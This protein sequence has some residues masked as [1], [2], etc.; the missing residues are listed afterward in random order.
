MTNQELEEYVGVIHQILCAQEKINEDLQRKID[1]LQQTVN[2][3]KQQIDFLTQNN[4]VLLKKNFSFINKEMLDYQMQLPVFGGENNEKKKH[5]LII[6]LTTFP[7]RIYDIKYTLFSLL[8]Q[9]LQADEILLWLSEE[10]FPEKEQ[11]ILAELLEWIKAHGII[12]KWC[13]KDICAFKKQIFSF[14][15]YQEDI[16]VSD[17]DDIFY[18]KHGLELR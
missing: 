3:Q 14:Q 16:I 5:K 17:D 7:G 10:E 6:S 2:Y 9:T 18:P 11:D 15:E 4:W 8:T 12:I 1:G 13:K